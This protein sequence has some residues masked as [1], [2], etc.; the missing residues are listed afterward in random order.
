MRLDYG[1]Q[2]SPY[3]LELSIGTLLKPKLSDIAKITFDKFNYFEVLITLTPELYFSSFADD[4]GME[5]WSELSD[6]E[7]SEI[8][9]YDI[10]I[11]NDALKDLFLEI[12][13]FF[14]QQT[15]IFREG[16]FVILDTLE[17][18]I[19]DLEEVDIKGVIS[20]DNISEVLNVLAQICCINEE[21]DEE[22]NAKFKN[23]LAEKLFKR[24]KAAKKAEKKKNDKNYT[25]PN[26]IS[27]VSNRHPS[28]TPTSVW[29]LTVFQLLDSFQRLQTNSI[30]D[31][32]I[33]RVS[34]WG[35]EKGAF[36][37]ALWYKNQYESNSRSN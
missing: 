7:K 15:V 25:I 17:T 29:D 22:P 11:N 18:N 28:I 4:A 36:D 12:F 2:L 24:M 23:A 19:F 14:F 33:T 32:D 16:Y 31:I 34:V 6:D 10:I 20:K 26:L 37:A 13:N 30:Y 35:D 9:I 1:S 5:Y 21:N 3:P 27:A 8:S